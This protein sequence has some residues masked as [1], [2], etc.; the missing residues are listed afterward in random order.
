MMIE[1][2]GKT[3]T[4]P[5]R[6]WDRIR[7][8]T[9]DACWFWTGNQNAYGYGQISIDGLD[10]LAHRIAWTIASGPILK[11]MCVLHR[12]DMRS[13]VNPKHL[14]LGSH[15]DNTADMMVKGRVARGFQ[16]PQT[17]LSDNDVRTIRALAGKM[18]QSR[19]AARF[20]I[21]ANHVSR[22]LSGVSRSSVR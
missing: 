16:L 12:C 13:C 15:A 14:F 7:Q 5:Q 9:D 10:L 6:Y 4:L 21:R 19:I 20:G 8:T 2:S 17:R 22:I 1:I 18:S 3:I 11:G